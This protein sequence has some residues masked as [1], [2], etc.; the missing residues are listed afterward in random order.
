MA[1]KKIPQIFEN[2]T[3][4]LLLLFESSFLSAVICHVE[5]Y[6]PPGAFVMVHQSVSTKQGAMQAVRYNEAP[7]SCLLLIHVRLLTSYM[8]TLKAFFQCLLSVN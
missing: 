7:F 5:D 8:A 6:V 4:Y 3:S 2:N 1:G